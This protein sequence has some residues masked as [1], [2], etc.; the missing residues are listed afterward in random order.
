MIVNTCT[1][2]NTLYMWGR[3]AAAAAAERASEK[4]S[5]E[6]Q[7]VQGNEALAARASADK[8]AQLEAQTLELQVYI[9]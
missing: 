9:Y 6:L 2:E 1:T 7:N 4:H 5:L 3:Q 8:I